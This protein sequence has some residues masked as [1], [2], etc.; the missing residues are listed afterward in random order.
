MLF[1]AGAAG[2][3]AIEVR[4]AGAAF[5]AP[6][7]DAWIEAYTARHDHVAM[8]FHAV[9]SGV[10]VRRFLAGEVPFGTSD[11]VLEDAE[12][13]AVA[14]GLT[15]VP[16]TA[17]AIA[18]AYNLPEVPSGLAL[19][20]DA[21]VGIFLG[22]ITEW[23][24][25]R[26]VALNPETDLPG[27][28][29]TVVTRRDPAGSTAAFTGHLSAI[30]P[31][32]RERHGADRVVAWPV[33]ARSATG[34]AGVAAAIGA[35]PGAIGYV[36][37][38]TARRAELGVARL[39]N[40]AG[41]LVAPG[42]EAGRAAL[43]ELAV[44]PARLTVDPTAATAYPVVNVAWLLLRRHYPR[45]EVRRAVYDFADWGLRAGQAHVA[46]LGYVPLPEAVAARAQRRLAR[47]R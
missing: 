8:T 7:L 2:A 29:I 3:G 27:L 10:G 4:G 43:A 37:D 26:I 33:Q 25:P 34:E 5:A 28:A 13:A 22:E 45:A 6:V 14:A 21:L 35:S 20:R 19:S 17:G 24:D 44:A 39:E 47:A 15:V 11:A 30:S 23:R 41:V 16:A 12:A 9:G 38:V 36:A 46:E 32:W 31:R 18:V 1:L 40:A 42:P